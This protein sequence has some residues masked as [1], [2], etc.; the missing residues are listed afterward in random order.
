M[1]DELISEFIKEIGDDMIVL[2]ENLSLEFEKIKK[3]IFDN[4]ITELYDSVKIIQK[5]IDEKFEFP[6]LDAIDLCLECL[7]HNNFDNEKQLLIKTLE[8]YRKN[9]IGNK[10]DY[11]ERL[12]I[13]ERK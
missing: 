12:L 10:Y 6:I 3:Y 1:F 9:I 7:N 4:S 8:K 11:I 13:E 2:E 5:N